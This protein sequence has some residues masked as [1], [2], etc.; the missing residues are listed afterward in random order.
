MYGY[1]KL[2]FA[3]VANFVD[4]AMGIVKFPFHMCKC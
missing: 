2:M 3:I 4:F 1:G